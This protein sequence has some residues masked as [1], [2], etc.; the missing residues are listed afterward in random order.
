VNPA[1]S[2]GD[3]RE[4]MDRFERGLEHLL[5]HQAKQQEHLEMHDRI[6]A[7]LFNSHDDLKETT[8]ELMK[9]QILFADETRKAFAQVA[10]KLTELTDR[11]NGLTEAQKHT[12]ERLNQVIDIVDDIVK[13][14]PPTQGAI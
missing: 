13:N 4:R 8:R 6:L 1:N 9:H 5:H 7:H 10:E 12:D 3:W 14:R 11:M 2:N